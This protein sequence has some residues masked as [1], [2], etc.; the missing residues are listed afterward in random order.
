[1]NDHVGQAFGTHP[2]DRWPDEPEVWHLRFK[3]F[4]LPQ[5]PDFV[6][7][8]SLIEAY[9]RYR[10]GSRL[11]PTGKR[12][13]PPGR[14]TRQAAAFKWRERALDGDLH[15]LELTTRKALE[16]RLAEMQR[17]AYEQDREQQVRAWWDQH[18]EQHKGR[19]FEQC[20]DVFIM[21]DLIRREYA[22]H[23]VTL[24]PEQMQREFNARKAAGAT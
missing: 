21:M 8:R 20:L 12:I 23:G 17:V 10:G 15:E 7:G 22:A 14:W 11:G 5:T 24:S 9:R 4:F 2:W 16:D 1:V 3:Q 18:P 6:L 19:S 13:K